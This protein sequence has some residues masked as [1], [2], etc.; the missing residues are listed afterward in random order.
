MEMLSYSRK[1]F[2]GLALEEEN[3]PVRLFE[4]AMRELVTFQEDL[5]AQHPDFI[6][7]SR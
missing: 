3:Y 4:L 7:P 6:E 5:V 2:A 1:P